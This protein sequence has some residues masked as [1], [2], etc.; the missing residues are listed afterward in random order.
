MNTLFL[1]LL[2]ILLGGGSGFAVARKYFVRVRQLK[3]C[4]RFLSRL[5][6]YLEFERL[7]TGEL[8][9]HAL[10][11]GGLDELGFLT[12]TAEQLKHNVN[13]PMIWKDSLEKNRSRLALLAEDYDVL[14]QLSDILGAYDAQTQQREI[15]SLQRRLQENQRQAGEQNSRNGRLARSLGLLGGIAAAILIV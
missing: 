11:G 2:F 12:D 4:S 6:T 14:L 5:Q 3:L 15:G 10:S 9:A 8:M 1:G 7:T 13:F